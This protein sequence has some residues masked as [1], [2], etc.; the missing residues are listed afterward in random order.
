M[1]SKSRRNETAEICEKA[2]T[3][4]GI[5]IVPPGQELADPAVVIGAFWPHK[6]VGNKMVN[7]TIRLFMN[8]DFIF[9]TEC[10]RRKINLINQELN[11]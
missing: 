11:L 1:E 8:F 7:A 5:V 10:F 6:I 9:I 2:V 3:V 4:T